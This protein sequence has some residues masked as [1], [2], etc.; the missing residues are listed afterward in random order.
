MT[1]RWGPISESKS[2]PSHSQ[3][4]RAFKVR[5]CWRKMEEKVDPRWWRARREGSVRTEQDHGPRDN[6]PV[7]PEKKKEDTD[8]CRKDRR[9]S[10]Q[11]ISRMLEEK[12]LSW[13]GATSESEVPEKV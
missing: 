12:V 13:T 8:W 10:T 1:S 6:H 5:P 11:P 2:S 9:R 4:G 3:K 7:E